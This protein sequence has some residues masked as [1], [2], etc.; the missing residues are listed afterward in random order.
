METF[1]EKNLNKFRYEL[2]Y[3]I[4]RVQYHQLKKTL[5]KNYFFEKHRSNVINN[6][7]FDNNLKSYYENIE[8]LSKRKKTRLRWYGETDSL[9][10]SNIEIKIKDG[11]VGT[12]R[13][14]SF[15]KN[16]K[17]NEFN[18]INFNVNNILG[19]KEDEY[20]HVQLINS[21]NREYY[22]SS[23]ARITIDTN[24]KYFDVNSLERFYGEKNIIVEIKFNNNNNYFL[25]IPN[26]IDLKISKYSKYVNGINYLKKAQ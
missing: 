14:F 5:S 8:G 11:N 3:K 2:K 9:I 4:N 1:T 19:I 22:F 25:S 23:H 15:S 16:I 18:L 20:L 12:K 17:S 7:Y 10:K 13:R 26:Q 21:Y 6:I 24:I